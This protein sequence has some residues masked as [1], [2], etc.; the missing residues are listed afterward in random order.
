[1]RTSNYFGVVNSICTNDCYRS[2]VIA[3]GYESKT[4]Q[5]NQKAL[6]R[7]PSHVMGSIPEHYIRHFSNH[8]IRFLQLHWLIPMKPDISVFVLFNC[9]L[10]SSIESI[11]LITEILAFHVCCL[12]FSDSQDQV[13]VRHHLYD[14]LFCMDW[15]TTSLRVHHRSPLSASHVDSLP[16]LED[17]HG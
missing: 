12:A 16:K 9:S 7:S 3:R 15:D 13:Q 11:Q 14:S 1:M 4:Q 5:R 2:R 10:S 8:F 17:S 6:L